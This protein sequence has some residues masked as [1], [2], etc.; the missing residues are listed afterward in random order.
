MEW[1]INNKEWLFSGVGVVIIVAVIRYLWTKSKTKKEITTDKSEVSIPH[2][3][4][5]EEMMGPKARWCHRW[6]KPG[7]RPRRAWNRGM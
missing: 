3:E 1:I 4:S 7:P 2:S 5:A 6:W